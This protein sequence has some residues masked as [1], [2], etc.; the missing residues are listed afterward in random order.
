MSLK[1]SIS[2]LA[3][4]LTVSGLIPCSSKYVSLRYNLQTGSRAQHAFNPMFTMY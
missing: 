4:G 3:E 1:T 2:K